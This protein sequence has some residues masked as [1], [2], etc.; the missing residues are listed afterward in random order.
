MRLKGIG[1]EY[2]NKLSKVLS[3]AKT[4]VTPKLVSEILE[5]P[6]QESGRILARWCKHGWVKR[7]KRGIYVPVNIDDPTTELPIAEPWAVINNLYAP[8]YIGGF[9]AIKHWDLSEQIFEIVMFFTTEEVKDRY[10]SLGGIRFQLK[11][12]NSK[13]FFGTKSI[14][15]D[16]VKIQVS[17]PS[18]TIA[19]F[20]D[21]P[22]MAGGMRVAR[23]IFSEYLDSK[24]ID[25]DLIVS[26]AVRMNNK[27]IIRRLGFLIETIGRHDLL[28]GTNLTKIRF[29]GYSKFDPTVS[30][31]VFVRKW[32][33]IVPE[34]WKQEYDQKK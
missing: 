7:I 34:I 1:K 17:D 3:L 33:L 21:D 27:T 9:S 2:R 12:I 13:K 19:D 16:N 10:L 25:I 28:S 8:G 6:R 14:W 4:V 18:K 29:R 31:N 23:D 11:R 15:L 32:G 20:L 24:Y 22:K 5:I 30:N 26:Y